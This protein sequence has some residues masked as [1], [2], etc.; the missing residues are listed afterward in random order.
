MT[1]RPFRI[2]YPL[3]ARTWRV[4]LAGVALLL[5]VSVSA[6]S[7]AQ[8]TDMAG[9]N[10]T[11]PEKLGKIW[12]AYPPLTY[13]VYALDPSLLS[14]WNSP[15]NEKIKPFVATRYHSLPILGGWFGQRTPNIETLV[16][17]RPDAALVWDE[18]LRALPGMAEQLRKFSIP[19]VAVKMEKIADYPET[20][21][22][23]GRLL[24][25]RARAREL[26]DSI[27]RTIKEMRAFAASIPPSARKSVYYAIGP[28][29][30]TNDCNHMPFLEESIELA[31]GKSAHRCE[32]KEQLGNKISLELVMTYN[33]DVIITQDDVFYRRVLSDQRWQSIRAV[34]ERRVYRIPS[35]PFNW[36]NY[37]PSFMRALGIKWL[38]S[39]IYPDRYKHDL[40]KDVKSFY[41]QF[42]KL[43]LTQRQIEAILTP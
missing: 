11:V 13:L 19:V 28:D 2:S 29:G 10:V 1:K 18:S 41:K 5:A 20:F 27:T 15:L 4:T 30:L 9:R 43:N 14:G 22:F 33:P 34:K 26:A 25:R 31:G 3:M 36:L 37:P 35:L 23:L 39:V 24:D 40:K 16:L 7:A 38:A 17:A 12:S 21:L 8:V 42:L 32:R 6:V